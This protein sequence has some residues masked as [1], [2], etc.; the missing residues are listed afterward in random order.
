[1]KLC[2]IHGGNSTHRN[3][4]LF[5]QDCMT[6]TV[7]QSQHSCKMVTSQP[8]IATAGYS[9]QNSI[10]VTSQC[11]CRGTASLFLSSWWPLDF[12][13][14]AKVNSRSLVQNSCSQWFYCGGAYTVRQYTRSLPTNFGNVYQWKEI[15]KR[16]THVKSTC[17]TMLFINN[18]RFPFTILKCLPWCVE[19]ESHFLH[20]C[21]H[22]A[23]MFLRTA[24]FLCV[25]S[26]EI[27]INATLV[28]CYAGLLIGRDGGCRIIG[29]KSHPIA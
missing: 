11:T 7:S 9:L 27:C 16:L 2:K 12:F 23:S 17:T 8:G 1:M 14:R 22:I 26:R 4:V 3:I 13:A 21:V 28:L 29:Q 20:F 19:I 15:E 6:I 10:L 5:S 25:I 24:R 18:V